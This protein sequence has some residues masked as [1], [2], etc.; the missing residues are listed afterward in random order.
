MKTTIMIDKKVWEEFRL[1][2]N[3]DRGIRELSRAIEEALEDEAPSLLI[4]QALNEIIGET[5]II[6]EVKTIE[7]LKPTDAGKTIREMR[8]HRI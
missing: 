8:S 2:V 7:P 3:E 5:R 1:K 6:E 4:T